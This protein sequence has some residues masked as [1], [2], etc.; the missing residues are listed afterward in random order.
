MWCSL[1]SGRD[2]GLDAPGPPWSST[3]T[4]RPAGRTVATVVRDLFRAVVDEASSNQLNHCNGATR[5]TA[6]EHWTNSTKRGE[7]L[8]ID[9]GHMGLEQLVR[10]TPGILS[11]RVCAEMRRVRQPA[12][13][14]P[15]HLI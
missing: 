15:D 2:E 4:F 9:T 11:V 8:G 14:M 7:D 10:A 5:T 3:T 6:E 12:V 13:R 1:E